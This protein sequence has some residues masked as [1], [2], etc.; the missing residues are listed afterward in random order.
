MG[1]NTG[2]QHCQPGH[3]SRRDDKSGVVTAPEETDSLVWTTPL[4]E[5]KDNSALLKAR[6]GQVGLHHV[7]QRQVSLSRTARRKDMSGSIKLADKGRIKMGLT[8]TALDKMIYQATKR[9]DIS[10]MA[11]ALGERTV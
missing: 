3:T 9:K 8:T 2:S 10:D 4:A 11:T 6:T 5:R 7:Q 1:C